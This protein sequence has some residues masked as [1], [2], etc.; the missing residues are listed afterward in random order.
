MSDWSYRLK[1]FLYQEYIPVTKG[2]AIVSAVIF[3]LSFIPALNTFFL[4]FSLY[5]AT[6]LLA[7]WTLITYPFINDQGILSIIFGILW[8]WMIGGSLERSWG[9]RTYGLFLFLVTLI[10]GL[11]IAT[12]GRLGW[13][14]NIPIG[15]L[16]LPLLGLTWA[17]A[18][19]LPDQEVMF[20]GIIPLKAQVLA[21]INAA[22]I[23]VSYLRGGVMLSIACMTGI[24]VVYLFLDNGPFGRG[25]RYKAW[26]RGIS[27]Q[28]NR[29]EPKNGRKRLRV[30]K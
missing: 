30:I 18:Q 6:G 17:W 20:W 8:L 15:N 1:R 14:E 12:F 4:I 16:W 24:A 7:P 11:V 10:T 25:F 9:S 22:I 2:L 28:R 21:W 13:V 3:L 5:P 29:R 27:G 26:S 23:F 19:I